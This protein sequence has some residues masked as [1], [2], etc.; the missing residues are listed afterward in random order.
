M[1][2]P[3]VQGRNTKEKKA[4]IWKKKRNRLDAVPVVPPLVAVVVSAF[5]GGFSFGYR[6][7]VFEWV[8]RPGGSSHSGS[9]LLTRPWGPN[10]L[11]R[12]G[13][14]SCENPHAHSSC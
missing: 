9:V 4:P 7:I 5:F 3:A 10:A 13:E 12:G 2:F 14:P 8:L 6:H 1:G 11:L